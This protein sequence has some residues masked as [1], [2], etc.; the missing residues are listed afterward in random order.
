MG[1]DQ[2]ESDGNTVSPCTYQLTATQLAVLVLGT[3][4]ANAVVTLALLQPH[5][6]RLDGV[7]ALALQNN[8]MNNMQ[9]QAQLQT[10]LHVTAVA[11]R[12][13]AMRGKQEPAA[14]DPADR[15]PQR[16]AGDE[17]QAARKASDLESCAGQPFSSADF[18]KSFDAFGINLR[19]QG[20]NTGNLRRLWGRVQAVEINV[21]RDVADKIAAL[22]ASVTAVSSEVATNVAAKLR[23]VGAAQAQLT[24]DQAAARALL[25][26]EMSAAVAKNGAAIAVA[27]KKYTQCKSLTQKGCGYWISPVIVGTNKKNAVLKLGA[28]WDYCALA[29]FVNTH[30]GACTIANAGSG[31]TLTA[32]PVNSGS[33]SGCAAVCF[34]HN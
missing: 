28:R 26:K 6:Q 4:L 13:G 15:Q 22:N 34:R 33:H 21:G 3:L 11:A 19:E 29:G 8:S 23:A 9:A 5:G 18:T 14:A 10:D 27:A 25:K 17:E 12:L 7:N 1:K 30:S 20:N 16:P 32:E 2:T 24:K 31:W